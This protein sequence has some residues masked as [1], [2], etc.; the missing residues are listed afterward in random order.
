MIYHNSIP[1][2]GHQIIELR[3]STID[4]IESNVDL[5]FLS[6][7]LLVIVSS[8]GNIKSSTKLYK[9]NKLIINNIELEMPEKIKSTANHKHTQKI[10]FAG[11]LN[12]NTFSAIN[13]T[14]IHPIPI[15]EYIY[16]K[17]SILNHNCCI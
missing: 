8:I 3:L 7:N 13:G 4:L 2:S 5:F 16:H 12:F 9:T 17:F 10:T 6:K 1:A 11:F 15:I 14:K